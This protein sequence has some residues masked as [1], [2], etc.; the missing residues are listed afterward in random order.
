[1]EIVLAFAAVVGISLIAVLASVAGAAGG[2]APTRASSGR[3]PPPRAGAGAPAPG[4]TAARHGLEQPPDRCRRGGHH[5][6]VRAR[7]ASP[8]TSGTTTSTGA[9]RTAGTARHR[10]SRPPDAAPGIRPRLAAAGRRRAASP[11]ARRRPPTSRTARRALMAPPDEPDWDWDAGR[12]AQPAG[13]SAAPAAG[14]AVSPARRGRIRAGGRKVNPL[15]LVA[16]YAAFGIGVIVIAVSLV[17]GAVSG[18]EHGPHAAHLGH[19]RAHPGADAARRL[20][21]RECRGQATAAG[22]LS[23]SAAPRSPGRAP[24]S[25]MLAPRPGV[26][27][28]RVARPAPRAAVPPARRAARRSTPAPALQAP[29]TPAPVAPVTPAAPSGGG[30]GGG[31][32]E[33]CLE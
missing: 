16:L 22:L 9:A 24:R 20:R 30:G 11:R 3:R 19:R 27:A 1:M 25:G 17:S 31:G 13:R 21:H 33:F 15:V 18:P 32:C 23:T 14:V 4:G 5:D 29:V 6:G 12:L 10:P 28:P 8:T 7:H 26:P 2:C